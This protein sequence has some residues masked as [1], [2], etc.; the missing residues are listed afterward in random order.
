MNI[1]IDTCDALWFFT[2]SNQLSSEKRQI[3]EDAEN[4]I[5]F[6]AVSASEIAIK[7]SLGKLSLPKP[8]EIYLPELRVRHHFAELPLH[9]SAALLLASLPMIHRDPFDR[10]LICQS[11]A[12]GLTLLSSDPAMRQYPQLQLI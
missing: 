3:I 1:L 2:G 10:Q 6:S 9:E 7:Y 5:F 8:P 4:I 11:L 12:H